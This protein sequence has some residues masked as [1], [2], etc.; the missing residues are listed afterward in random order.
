M[1]ACL[2]I[3]AVFVSCFL[4]FGEEGALKCRGLLRRFLGEA[5][6]LEPLNDQARHEP[7]AHLGKMNAIG[8]ERGE[9][10]LLQS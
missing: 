5:E 4:V 1:F 3:G 10:F 8:E 7:A 2:L 9:M 6:F